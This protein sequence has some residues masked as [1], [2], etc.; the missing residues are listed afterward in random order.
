MTTKNLHKLMS[1]KERVKILEHVLNGSSLNTNYISKEAG[2]NKGLVSRY[3]TLLVSFGIL[4]KKGRF[5]TLNQ[6]SPIYRSVKIMFNIIKL[7]KILPFDRRIVGIGVYGSYAKG[8]NN[9]SSDIDIWIKSNSPL[10]EEDVAK[11]EYEMTKKLGARLNV[12]VLYPEKAE[13]LRKED[14]EFYYSIVSGSILLWGE[15]LGD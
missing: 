4:G 10:K 7:S 8:T 3:F 13:R 6:K 5:Y 9:E 2:V 1:T 12:T 11:F 14:K 15:G